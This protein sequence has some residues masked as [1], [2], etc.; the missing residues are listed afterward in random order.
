MDHPTREPSGGPTDDARFPA[1]RWA[2]LPRPGGTEPAVPVT[3]VRTSCD[4]GAAPDLGPQVLSRVGDTARV[5]FRHRAP[6]ASAV[7]L[8]VNGWWRPEPATACDLRPLADGWWE[9]VFEVPA[10]WRASYA[11]AEHEGPEDPP[12]WAEG[13]KQAGLSLVA[14]RGARRGHRAPRGGD[15]RSV[16]ALPED[17]PFGCGPL[18]Q[19]PAPPL[20]ALEIP[21]IEERVRWWAARPGD[22][23]CERLRGDEPLPLLVVTDGA[24]HADRLGTPQR[25]RRGVASGML[26][27][28]AA[29]LI[30]SGERRG[31]VLGV[32]GGHARWIA[33][34]LVPRLQAE[35]LRVG[36]A[37]ASVPV[38]SDPSRVV[39]TGS[40]FGGL[41]A[42]FALARAPH[43]VGTAIAQ[44]VSLWR[45]PAGALA[46]PLLAA[47]REAGA[48]G[49][50]LRLRLQAGRFEGT[51]HADAD[52]MLGTVRAGAD[53]A[54]LPLDAELT[55]HSGG[56]DWAWWQPEMLRALGE[57]LR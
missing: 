28:L 5:R 18:G 52:A 2:P 51:M 36:A 45:Y 19:E 21:G 13:L 32:P 4:L 24:Q 55:L 14:D 39:V 42:L 44:S 31:E 57:L 47:V 43:V 37:E 48:A 56:H 20:H 41:T 8:Q 10:D 33:E 11:F 34:T 54:G 16:I 35:G 26:P 7:A 25:L 40:S 22:P 1:A 27:P 17:G 29:V 6:R 30:D 46:E 23:G 49:S 12:W 15:A 9:G 3:R 38:T 50:P 53:A